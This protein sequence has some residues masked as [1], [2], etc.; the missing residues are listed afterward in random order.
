MARVDVCVWI[1]WVCLGLGVMCCVVLCGA[2]Q[3]EF[4]ILECA[5]PMTKGR[6]VKVL[7]KEYW[8]QL[9]QLLDIMITATNCYI[10]S[11]RLVFAMFEITDMGISLYTDS[12]NMIACFLTGK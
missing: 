11:F 1:I 6:E 8:L 5:S 3:T 4:I 7:S 2:H 10:S 9:K 12:V